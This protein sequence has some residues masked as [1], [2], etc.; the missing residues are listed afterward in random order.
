MFSGLL[1]LPFS[2]LREVVGPKIITAAFRLRRKKSKKNERFWARFAQAQLLLYRLND[3]DIDSSWCRQASGTANDFY[4][5]CCLIWIGLVGLSCKVAFLEE[6]G[7]ETE[8][9]WRTDLASAQNHFE[10]HLL[11]KL[12]DAEVDAFHEFALAAVKAAMK[13]PENLFAYAG[14]TR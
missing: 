3:A 7:F 9:S 8:M 13:D 5:A 2:I 1:A 12:K 11:C 10:E 6:R 14:G 4:E